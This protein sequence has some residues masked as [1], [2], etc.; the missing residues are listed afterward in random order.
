[1]S[2]PST[3]LI[4]NMKSVQTSGPSS[5]TS[6]N[7]IAQA[8]PITD[9]PGMVDNIVLVLQEAAVKVTNLLAVTDQTVPDPNY[10]LLNQISGSLNGKSPNT[11]TLIANITQCETNGVSTASAALAIAQAGPI[12]DVLGMIRSIHLTLTEI[13]VD[14]GGIGGV[15]GLIGLTDPTTDGSNLA[16]LQNVLASLV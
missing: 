10:A 4:A 12:E 1:M 13:K 5:V 14:I 2:T 9:Y 8:G 16:L 3:S 6:A 11:T 15:Q 7:A